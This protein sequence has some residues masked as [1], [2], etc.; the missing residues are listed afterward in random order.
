MKY[1]QDDSL[2]QCQRLIESDVEIEFNLNRDKILCYNNRGCIPK[3]LELRLLILWEANN[4]P[5]A[6]Y[7]SN[8][9]MYK[10]LQ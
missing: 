5:Y 9:K 7:P 2:V 3:D 4:N 10:D 8:K 6:M 1:M